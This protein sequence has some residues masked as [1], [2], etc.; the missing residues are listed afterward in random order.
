MLRVKAIA[1][2]IAQGFRVVSLMDEP[3][4][5]TNVKD[6]FDAT[7]A[8]VQRF[9]HQKNCLFI[10]SSHQIE[11]IKDHRVAKKL[12]DFRHFEA[13]EYGQYLQFDYRLRPGVSEQRLG[14]RV[15]KEKGVL[16]LLDNN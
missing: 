13:Q 8:L 16:D 1:K 12:I 15:L 6:A 2:A 7:L 9:A 4:K 14:M 11:I 5:G 10:L 3:F